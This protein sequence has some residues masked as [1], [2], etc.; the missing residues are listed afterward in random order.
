MDDEDLGLWL[1]GK[2]SVRHRLGVMR[3]MQMRRLDEVVG[4]LRVHP[5]APQPPDDEGRLVGLLTV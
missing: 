1:L 2:P 4:D 5:D 3:G